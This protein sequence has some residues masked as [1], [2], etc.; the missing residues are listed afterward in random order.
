[1]RNNRKARVSQDAKSPIRS[2][3]RQSNSCLAG[4]WVSGAPRE[5]IRRLALR[6]VRRHIAAAFNME[7]QAFELLALAAF[8]SQSSALLATFCRDTAMCT[9]PKKARPKWEP[10]GAA[11]PAWDPFP[12]PVDCEPT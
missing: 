9:P 4:I 7:A 12:Q 6:V 8:C 3:Q 11:K 2:G 5:L 1:M 10:S